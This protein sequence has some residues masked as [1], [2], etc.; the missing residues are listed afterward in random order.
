MLALCR[1]QVTVDCDFCVWQ[2]QQEWETEKQDENLKTA[3]E[4]ERALKPFERN[5]LAEKAVGVILK[6][7]GNSDNPSGA[8]KNPVPLDI[9]HLGHS[10][11]MKQAKQVSQLASLP[12]RQRRQIA[13]A[14]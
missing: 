10:I 2:V 8:V 13:S 7:M 1:F 4:R 6:L 3:A 5:T 14:R 9:I 11:E 12:A